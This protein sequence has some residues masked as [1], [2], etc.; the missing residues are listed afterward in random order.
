MLQGLRTVKGQAHAVG[1]VQRALQSQ[2]LAG[3]YL[4][5]GPD[6]VGKERTARA[7]A[8][9]SMCTSPREDRDAC[10]ECP[11]CRQVATNRHVDLLTLGRTIDVRTQQEESDPRTE[12]T[13][14][15]VRMLQADRL[16][17]QPFGPIRWV[18]VRDAHELNVEASNALLKT[19]EEPPSRTHFVLCT[20]RASALLT[21]IRSRCQRVRFVPLDSEIVEELLRADGVG[22]AAAHDA[23]AY[24]EGSVSRAKALADADVLASRKSWVDRIVATIDAGRPGAMVDLAEELKRT[25]EKSTRD[26]DEIIEVLSMLQRRYRDDAIAAAVEQ[27]DVATR[28]A[29]RAEAAGRTAGSL[30]GGVNAQMA[31]EGLWIRLR[32]ARAG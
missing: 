7:L 21:T 20:S 16:I 22:P 19:L 18:V 27:A 9:A 11:S 15:K 23:A 13:I 5:E 3:T 17:Y 32:E 14:D 12:L 4:F 6:G 29:R 10:G 28:A 24:A 1:L 25:G 8:Q 2:R 31:L 26:R 30:V